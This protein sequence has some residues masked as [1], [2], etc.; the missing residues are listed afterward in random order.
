MQSIM[1]KAVPKT[2][3]GFLLAA[4]LVMPALAGDPPKM[5]NAGT[6]HVAIRGYDT[7]AYFTE[8]R[9]IKGQSE[10]V[11]SWRDVKWQFANAKHLGMF[12]ADPARYA[13]QFGGFCA[14]AL[15]QG[16]VKVVDPEAWTIVDKKLYLNFSQKGRVKFRQDLQG[17]IKKSEQNWAKRQIQN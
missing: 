12:A 13:P 16:V 5:I 10:F 14:M 4:A 8:G 15:T 17:N 1:M 11:F 7:V 3:S 2:L 6:D 9:P